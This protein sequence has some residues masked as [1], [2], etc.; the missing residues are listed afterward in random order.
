MQR[1]GGV[2]ILM[3]I[4]LNP[5]VLKK[6]QFLTGSAENVK[7]LPDTPALVPFDNTIVVFLNE[8]SKILMKDPESRPLSDIIT[9]AF[10]IRK[11]STSK[12]K[13]RFVIRDG[14]SYL[15]KGVVFH[16]APSNV[17]VNFLLL[18]M[19]VPTPTVELSWVDLK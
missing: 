14:N 2:A 19:P 8:V 1:L 6:I 5:D 9:F 12:L 16:I 3:Q 18:S 7:E 13:E 10:W 4:S 11:A 17:P 15:G